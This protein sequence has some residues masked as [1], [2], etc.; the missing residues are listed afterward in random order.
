[1]ATRATRRSG[2]DR[3]RGG[4]ENQGEARQPDGR[5]KPI[6]CP[7]ARQTTETDR[8]THSHHAAWLR[9]RHLRYHGKNT[10][11]G[12]TVANYRIVE[13]LGTGGMG[14]VYKAQDTR[15]NRYLALKFLKPERVTEDYKR[16]FFQEARSASALNHPGIIHIYDIGQ[17]EGADFIA[18][19]FVEGDRKS[20]V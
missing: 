14:V 3:A 2:R 16:R 20:V 13:E 18:M 10:V 19:E 8:L 17:W 12:Q 1:M 5:Q 15:L 4:R 9:P 6:V 7:T 11:V